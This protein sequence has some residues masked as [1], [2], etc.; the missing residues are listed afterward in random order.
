MR[1]VSTV[2][3]IVCNPV[4][5][6]TRLMPLK[7]LS[8]PRGELM[9]CQLATRLAKTVCEQLE[10]SMNAVTYLSDSTTALWWIR[11][12]PRTFRPFVANRVSEVI[13]ESDPAQWHHVRTELNVA[14][15]A[16]R[17]VPDNSLQAD[18]WWIRGPEFLWTERAEWPID[19]VPSSHCPT[20]EVELKKKVFNVRAS[21]GLLLDTAAYS[22]WNRLLRV[23]SWLLRYLGNLCNQNQR[24]SGRLTVDELKEA[25]QLWI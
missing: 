17:G 20:A 22:S 18:S 25:E 4:M 10:L 12:E 21:V 9:G 24:R 23:T 14:D 6:K 2:G 16:T 19:D 3:E 1:A 11:G 15:I 7:T 5:A 13:S 8:V